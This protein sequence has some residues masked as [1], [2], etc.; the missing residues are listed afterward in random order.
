MCVCVCI[1][2]KQIANKNLLSRTKNST[3]Y[4]VKAYM[5]KESKKRKEWICVYVQLIHFVVHL[6]LTQ[7][8]KSITLQ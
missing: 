1:Y 6:R 3:Q 2:I 8:C 7:H 4:S 5:G